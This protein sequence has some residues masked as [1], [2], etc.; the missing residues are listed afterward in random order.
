MPSSGERVKA[1]LAG[2]ALAPTVLEVEDVSD[3]CGAKF[4]VVVVSANFEGKK[5]L[6]RHRDV[7]EAL[8][9]EMGEIHAL[10]LKTWTPEQH[11]AKTRPDA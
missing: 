6:E 7:H 3:G 1:L 10:V 2:S 11:A 8:G 9:A 4:E 5:L